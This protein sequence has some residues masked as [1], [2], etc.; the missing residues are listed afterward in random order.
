MKKYWL[1]GL[2]VLSASV[3]AQEQP[4]INYTAGSGECETDFNRDG[5][6]DLWNDTSTGEASAVGLN[7]QY[8]I[9]RTTYTSGTGS[10]KVVVTGNCTADPRYVL[11]LRCE[12]I[13]AT[14]GN[15][16]APGE[17]V[18]V[19]LDLKTSPELVNVQYSVQ[20]YMDR[21]DGGAYPQ[22]LPWTRTVRPDWSS[23][24]GSFVMPETVDGRFRIVIYARI[25]PGATSG[26]MW[27]DN[28]VVRTERRLQPRQGTLKVARVTS[29]GSDWVET[30]QNYDLLVTNAPYLGRFKAQK[31]SIKTYYYT[32]GWEAATYNVNNVWVGNDTIGSS[33]D[34]L[35]Y[36]FADTYY[37]EWFLINYFDRR[38]S[39]PSGSNTR[40]YAMDFGNPA[41][42][43]VVFQNMRTFFDDVFGSNSTMAPDGLYFDRLNNALGMQTPR[44]PTREERLAK[45]LEYM[46]DFHGQVGSQGV[47][48]IANGY[49][50]QWNAGEF[51]PIQANNWLN[52]FLIE[53]FLINIYQNTYRT[54]KAMSDHLKS[55]MLYRDRTTIGMTR[56][57]TNYPHYLKF[58]I[59]GF[60]LVNHPNFY[61]FVTSENARQ[62]P[63]VGD[64]LLIPQLNLPMGTPTTEEYVR[65][66]GTDNRGALYKRDYTSGVALLNTSD[67]TAY[68]YTPTQQLRDYEGNIY[69]A[70]VAI[71][72]APR[73][74][75]VLY[76]P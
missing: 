65:L 75:L 26:T 17:T 25:L 10:Q 23:V 54:P 47:K 57:F 11:A 46:A 12:W 39:I 19:S 16:P 24:S 76:V 7:V 62:R 33:G 3:T 28:I 14:G 35:P 68:S 9:D 29:V 64:S 2:L 70:G 51:A 52:G 69:Q 49:V 22:L 8:A 74:G 13:P 20:A 44:Y 61:C 72:L 58:V 56:I 31:S 4:Y 45:L 18:Y 36:Q 53:G 59:A 15:Y 43:N 41:M 42:R 50:K 40:I 63:V 21:V 38:I 67:T 48:A 27:V 37:P 73:T 60:Y 34:F 1:I 32:L 55:M 30:A 71:E 66:A 6:V 5:V